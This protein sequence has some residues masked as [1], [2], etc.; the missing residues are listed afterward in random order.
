MQALAVDE[1][2]KKESVR[3][4]MLSDIL[5]QTSLKVPAA[6]E[7]GNVCSFLAACERYK[8]HLIIKH[9]MIA[10][11][12]EKGSCYCQE[13]ASGKQVVLVTGNPPQQYTLPVGWAQFMHR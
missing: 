5:R 11:G 4:S 9:S 1:K 3:A 7:R 6:V 10:L 12:P 8:D 2:L 13:C